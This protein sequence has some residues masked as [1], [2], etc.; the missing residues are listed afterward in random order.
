[1]IIEYETD[2]PGRECRWEEFDA[3]TRPY[4]ESE[5]QILQ[6]EF[7]KNQCAQTLNQ[8]VQENVTPDSELY[9]RQI[10]MIMF[11]LLLE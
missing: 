3:G 8:Y 9:I 7:E 2:V 1:M 4:T 11:W 5:I 6:T 10:Y